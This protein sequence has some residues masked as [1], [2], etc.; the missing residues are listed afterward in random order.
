MKFEK[1]IRYWQTRS[2][3]HTSAGDTSLRT[4]RDSRAG[5]IVTYR[6]GILQVE[7]CTAIRKCTL[8][9]FALAIH[10][11]YRVDTKASARL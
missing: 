5:L 3:A 7:P 6:T 9:D 11:I 10:S 2:A 1:G 8:F 4:S